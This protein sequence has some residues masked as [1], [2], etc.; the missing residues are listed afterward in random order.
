MENSTEN[1]GVDFSLCACVSV[2]LYTNN[3]HTISGGGVG[4]QYY[5]KQKKK[6]LVIY[7]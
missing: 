4:E 2:N 7:Y 3:T 5:T 6:R 1:F